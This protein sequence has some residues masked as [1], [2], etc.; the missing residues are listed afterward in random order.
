M[1]AQ[2][3]DPAAAVEEFHPIGFVLE[4]DTT[5]V[6]CAVCGLLEHTGSGFEGHGT[7]GADHA[8]STGHTVTERHVRTTVI[9]E[10][11]SPGTSPR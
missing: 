10:R 6:T 2:V 1:A 3:I 7:H 4:S 9:S 8:I 11:P 5:D